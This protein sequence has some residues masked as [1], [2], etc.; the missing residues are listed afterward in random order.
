MDAGTIEFAIRRLAKSSW[1]ARD[2]YILK[3]E[4]ELL[5]EHLSRIRNSESWDEQVA[6]D[7]H[8]VCHKR[9]TSTEEENNERIQELTLLVL[10]P[11]ANR[12]GTADR[13]LLSRLN[14]FEEDMRA[15]WG[16]YP[17][18]DPAWKQRHMTILVTLYLEVLFLPR[19]ADRS[20]SS[21]FSFRLYSTG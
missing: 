5:L 6:D 14:D 18:C 1:G 10:G 19:R 4:A 8:R 11:N 3:D 2:G 9:F 15:F 21:I 12:F 16:H 17:H 20:K 13:F 7:V